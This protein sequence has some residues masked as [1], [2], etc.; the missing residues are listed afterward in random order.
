MTKT[1]EMVIQRY[2]IPIEGADTHQFVFAPVDALLQE[3]EVFV[4]L[5]EA[6]L[7]HHDPLGGGVGLL[8]REG[9]V[10]EHDEQPVF[11]ERPH[12]HVALLQFHN[13]AGREGGGARG[14]EGH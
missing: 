8:L 1:L 2:S 5:H 3:A 9:A 12:T 14:H 13:P 6:G 11:E 10:V 4:G 7:G